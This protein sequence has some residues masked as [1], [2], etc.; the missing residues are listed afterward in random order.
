MRGDTKGMGDIINKIIEIATGKNAKIFWAIIIGSFVVFL[1]LYPYIDANYL[2]YNRISQRVDILDKIT[3][4]DTEVIANNVLLKQEYD[5][6]LK[7]IESAQDKS[8]I[9]ITSV[10]DSKEDENIKFVSGGFLF[11]I[12]SLFILFSKN[13]QGIP[14]MKKI[15][16]NIL[17]TMLCI[18]IGFLLAYIGKAL[19]TFINVWVNAV[20]FPILQLVIIGLLVYGTPNKSK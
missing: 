8:I 10:N 17:S 14:R 5:S 9:N 18:G 20:A 13:N 3:K 12:V 7:E 15:M 4:L 1:L 11:W 16:N 19:P 6:I 2:V